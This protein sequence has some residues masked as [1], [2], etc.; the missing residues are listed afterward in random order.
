MKPLN[1]KYSFILALAAI[2]GLFFCT[3][4]PLSYY[5]NDSAQELTNSSLVAMCIPFKSFHVDY[6]DNTRLKP[7]VQYSDSFLLEA[8]NSFLL[9]EGTQKFTM[10]PAQSRECSFVDTV[11]TRRFSS[12]FRDSVDTTLFSETSRKVRELALRCS[13]D[14]VILPF[15]CS[16]KQ[17]MR[18]P[19]TW[20]STSGPG[21][22]RPIGFSAVTSVHIQIWN[23]NGRLLFER[24]GRSDTGKPI[25]Y[26]LF[27]K[28]KPG[29]D[30]VVFAKK[31]YAPPL[32]K[33]LASS[34]KSA[35]R[36]R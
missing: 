8:A 6:V 18:Q 4:R 25:L 33:S 20:R 30:I 13:V 19:K 14:I 31:I 16:V 11:A 24:I 26:S 21:Y 17:Q 1:K 29:D 36:F 34:I 10:R 35:M 5:C 23:K 27:K 22:E 32:I 7:I 15:A 2:A 28:E 12:F 9:F 3:P